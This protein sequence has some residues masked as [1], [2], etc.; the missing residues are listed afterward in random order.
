MNTSKRIIYTESAEERLSKFNSEIKE[1]IENYL[2]ERKYVPGDELIEVT[3]S[4][5][6]EVAYRFRIQRPI[7]SNKKTLIPIVYSIIGLFTTTIGIFYNQIIS[8][9]QG[10]PKRLILIAG[11]MFMLLIS[12]FYL[13]LL[14]LREKQESKERMYFEEDLRRKLMK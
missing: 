8:L 12:W 7:R 6:D 4:D 10:D 9:L 11:G 5:I 3:A 2:R 13:Y 1:E 14:K